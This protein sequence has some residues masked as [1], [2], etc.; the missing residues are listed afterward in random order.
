MANELVTL[1]D[2]AKSFFAKV[3]KNAPSDTAAALSVINT[4]APEAE[5]VFA[6]VDPTL[7]VVANPIITEIQAD[8]ATVANLLKSGNTVSVGT[9]LTA[10]KSNLTAL[11]TAGHI[12]DPTSVTKVTG[13]VSAVDVLSNEFAQQAAA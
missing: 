11:L 7:A 13:I 4:I 1:F 12:T 5:L 9:F 2:D 10:I 8:L 6:L 3:F